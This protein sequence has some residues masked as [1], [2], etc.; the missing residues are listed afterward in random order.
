MIKSYWLLEELLPPSEELPLL[1]EPLEEP[2]DEPSLPELDDPLPEPPDLLEPLDDLLFPEFWLEYEFLLL[3][4]LDDFLYVVVVVLLVVFDEF[5]IER[6][7]LLSEPKFSWGKSNCTNAATTVPHSIAINPIITT[8]NIFDFNSPL[9][10]M[11]P[12]LIC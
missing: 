9:I 4:L 7:V 2:L 6:F 12:Y 10:I 3:L 8:N 5:P 1:L 11:P